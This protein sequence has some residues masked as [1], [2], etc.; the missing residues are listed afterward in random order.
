M[1]KLKPGTI[2]PTPEEEAAIMAGIAADPDN[3]ELDAE[4]WA[5]AKTAEEVHPDGTDKPPRSPQELWPERFAKK[6]EAV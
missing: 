2:W 5:T 4:Y 6:K 3:P 1:P